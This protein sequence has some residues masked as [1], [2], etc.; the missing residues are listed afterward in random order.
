MSKETNRENIIKELLKTIKD[1]EE[2]GGMP[3]STSIELT[4]LVRELQCA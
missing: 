1:S 4:A 3:Y 2:V